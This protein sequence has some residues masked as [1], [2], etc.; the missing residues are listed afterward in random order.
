MIPVSEPVLGEDEIR[1][2]DECLRSGW[3]S[4]SGQ[5]IDAFET[6]WAE[7]CGRSAGIAV[8]NGTVALQL[9]V[10]A[11]KLP[12]G[13]EIVMPT[14]TIISCALAALYNDCVPVFVD[15]D[16]LTWCM[17]VDRLEQSI[18][19]KTQAIMVVHIYGHPVD[20]DPVLALAKRHG[21]AVIEDA[22][23][24]HGA[25]YH[26]ASTG[27]WVRCGG[28]GDVSVFSFYANKLVTTGEGG[29]VLADDP[30]VIERARRLRNL[31]FLPERRFLHQE[32][33]FNFRMTNVQAAIGTGQVGRINEV[34]TRKREIAATYSA[35]LDSVRE[36][37][38]LPAEQ[39]WARSV[40]WMYG[41]V[42]G[43][44]E[45]DAEELGARM[46]EQGIETRP[47]FLGLHE[48]PALRERGLGANGRFPV[49]ERISRRGLYLPSGVGLKDAQIAQVADAVTSALS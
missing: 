25:A 10:A 6:S 1:N 28:L 32:L 7:Y 34:V 39:P 22:A 3:I 33:G 31:G 42:L 24:A 11:L 17:D 5:F 48:Q 37:V 19:A 41:L 2:V 43:E 35:A 49:A 21:L 8:A 4:S 45:L 47:F 46:A 23:E 40:Y 13:S 36:R 30:A 18:T 9:A 29:M 27:D 26:T 20:M 16:P 12:A 14:F 15:A 44:D 38:Q